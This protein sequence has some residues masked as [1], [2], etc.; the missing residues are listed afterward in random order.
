MELTATVGAASP[1]AGTPTGTVT[2]LD[3]GSPIGT[4]ALVNGIATLT[5]STLAVGNDTITTSY[6]GDGSFNGDTGSLAGNPQVVNQADTS[7]VVASDQNPSTFGQSVTFSATVAATPPGAGTPTGTVTFLD[8]ASPIG[9]GTLLG[10]VA[11]LTTSALTGGN[12]TIT[13]SYNGDGSFSGSTGSLTG[14]PQ[15]VNTAET[16]TT[17]TSDA[18]PSVFG[19]MVAFTATV[20]SPGGTPTGTVTFLDGATTIGTGTLQNGTATLTTSALAVGNHTITASYTGDTNFNGDSGS[21]TGNPQVVDKAD[22]ATSLT[23]APDPAVLG[24]AVTFTATVTPTAPGAGTPTGT[25]TFLDGATTIGT[26][27]LSHET[28]TFTTSSLSA[29]SHSITA[30]YGGDSSFNP[31]IA[32]GGRR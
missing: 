32:L 4:G 22:T 12:H 6:S 3:G 17:V 11:T 5:T 7:T 18:N 8:G 16:S 20:A 31:S 14:N 27:T 25:V 21:L 26:G 29:G 1:G 9:T 24:Q 15:V 23:S 28:A 2:F 19:Q 10:G 13:T 30:Q